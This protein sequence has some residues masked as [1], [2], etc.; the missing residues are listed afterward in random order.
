MLYDSD[1]SENK[2]FK[3]EKIEGI[4][5]AIQPTP[6]GKKVTLVLERSGICGSL[7]S[8]V[9]RSDLPPQR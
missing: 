3:T 4:L 9:F 1:Y 8:D 7:G 5:K 6:R 2:H